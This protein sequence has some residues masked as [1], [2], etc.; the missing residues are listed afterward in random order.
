MRLA[1]SA[2]GTSKGRSYRQQTRSFPEPTVNRFNKPETTTT[3]KIWHTT[4]VTRLAYPRFQLQDGRDL[5]RDNARATKSL[6]RED[7]DLR[8]SRHRS[9]VTLLEGSESVPFLA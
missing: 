4:R 1:V 7:I 3:K 9:L 2:R 5:R 6:L 8:P